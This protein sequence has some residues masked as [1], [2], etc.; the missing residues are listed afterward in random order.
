[1]GIERVSH[2]QCSDGKLFETQIDA[3]R[4]EARLELVSL[5]RHIEDP[6]DADMTVSYLIRNW[7]LIEPLVKIARNRED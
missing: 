2:W 7:D 6:T 1:M 4:Y 3:S 5:M